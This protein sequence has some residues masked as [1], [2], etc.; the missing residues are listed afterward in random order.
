MEQKRELRRRLKRK[1]KTLMGNQTQQMF[2]RK[3]GIGQGSLNRLLKGNQD[4]G[5]DLIEQICK[6]TGSTVEDLLG[7]P[8]E[9]DSN[10]DPVSKV[11]EG[12]PTLVESPNL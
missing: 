6:Y 9:I 10:T 12:L 4:A 7:G 3:I 5:I 1:L 8:D 2:A 11:D